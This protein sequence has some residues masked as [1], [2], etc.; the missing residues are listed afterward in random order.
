MYL[1]NDLFQRF[2]LLVSV[3]HALLKFLHCISECS[4]SSCSISFF[5]SSTQLLETSLLLW[6]KVF[7]MIIPRLMKC[8]TSR[9]PSRGDPEYSGRSR[10]VPFRLTSDRNFR[11]LCI[12]VLFSLA[13]VRLSRSNSKTKGN[14]K[15][16]ISY[17]FIFLA[18]WSGK[19]QF[20]EV[21]TNWKAALA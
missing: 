18:T 13:E 4:F 15:S 14:K 1:F 10:N 8:S 12:I 3:L 7:R 2:D 20:V 11:N 5:W 21:T 19:K 9:G 6:S 16:K 17:F